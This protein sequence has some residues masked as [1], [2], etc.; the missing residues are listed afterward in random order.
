[1]FAPTKSAGCPPE[2]AMVSER[3]QR[4]IDH[5]LDEA[6]SAIRDLA[7]DLV[8]ARAEAVLTLDPDNG[9]GRNYLAAAERKLGLDPSVGQVPSPLPSPP[10][11]AG[12]APAPAS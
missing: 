2:V 5:L 8:R 10:G 3:A 12:V 7:W 9:D 1:M 11:S 6:E 4:Q